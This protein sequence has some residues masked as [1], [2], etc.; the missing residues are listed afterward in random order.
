MPPGNANSFD[1]TKAIA[2]HLKRLN[3]HFFQRDARF[4]LIVAIEGN[5]DW[6]HAN[7]LAGTIDKLA[8]EF[9]PNN[10][11]PRFLVD[12]S[13]KSKFTFYGVLTDA[14]SKEAMVTTANFYMS[15][16]SVVLDSRFFTTHP[17]GVSAVSDILQRQLR[18]FRRLLNPKTG[19]YK[20]TGKG[21]Q[22]TDNDDV[23]VTFLLGI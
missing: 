18:Q 21:D 16:D 2:G 23:A 1:Q 13:K 14:H 17:G 9:M 11:R 4:Q 3:Y 7:D 10:P 6:T 19:R 8:H 5:L 12:V 15:T 20:I 22:N